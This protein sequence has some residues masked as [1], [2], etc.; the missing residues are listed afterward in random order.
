VSVLMASGG[1][2]SCSF[3]RLV[4]RCRARVALCKRMK[5]EDWFECAKVYHLAE[6]LRKA[7]KGNAKM[8]RLGIGAA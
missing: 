4:E 3:V 2:L 5:E 1:G 7:L 6:A 8:M